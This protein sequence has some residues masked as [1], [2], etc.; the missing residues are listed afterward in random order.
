MASGQ[1]LIAWTPAAN[2]PPATNW[3]TFDVRNGHPVLDFDDTTE[4]AAIFTGVMP[5]NYSGGSLTVYFHWAATSATSG[6]GAWTVSLERIGDNNLDID[7]DS[8]AAGASASAT[9]VPAA[10]GTV[11]ITSATIA[12]AGLDSVAVGDAFRIKVSRNVATD[13][14]VGDLELVAI[15]VKEA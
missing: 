2:E 12:G 6:T 3:A 15:E 11:L 9:T 4:E 8:F 10:A 14:A 5:R 1:T 7:A 13:S